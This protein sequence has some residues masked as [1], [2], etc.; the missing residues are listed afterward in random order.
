VSIAA[1]HDSS[2]RHSRMG[3]IGPTNCCTLEPGI[4]AIHGENYD[5]SSVTKKKLNSMTIGSERGLTGLQYSYRECWRRCGLF[6]RI[7]RHEIRLKDGSIHRKRP[8]G[9]VVLDYAIA[10]TSRSSGGHRGVLIEEQVVKLTAMLKDANDTLIRF[11]AE[12]ARHDEGSASVC[13]REQYRVKVT[14]FFC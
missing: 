7:L 3:P 10:S 8:R 5:N 4:S 1:E 9:G 11:K 13:T 6:E 14:F 12:Q 2:S